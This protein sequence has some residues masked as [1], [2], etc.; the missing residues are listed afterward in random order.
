MLNNYLLEGDSS[1][2]F[3][4]VVIIMFLSNS[5]QR[6]VYIQIIDDNITSEFGERMLMLDDKTCV[7]KSLDIS[8][9]DTRNHF[10]FKCMV[11]VCAL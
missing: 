1:D 6:N 5:V 8:E 4:D 7:A 9:H 11:R 3:S 2:E 10:Q